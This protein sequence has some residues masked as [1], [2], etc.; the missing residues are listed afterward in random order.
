[1]TA[2]LTSCLDK[3]HELLKIGK[4]DVIDEKDLDNGEEINKFY[5][6]C[7]LEQKLLRVTPRL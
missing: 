1:M 6:N 2:C 5:I 4:A 7:E 3:V